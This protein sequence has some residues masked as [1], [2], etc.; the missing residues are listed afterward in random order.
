MTVTGANYTYMKLHDKV[1][2]TWQD[3]HGVVSMWE[4]QDEYEEGLGEIRT[5]GYFIKSEKSVLYLAQSISQDQYGRIIRIPVG[6]IVKK[7]RL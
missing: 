5:I 3:S 4:F 6:C 1:E 7:T 2:I